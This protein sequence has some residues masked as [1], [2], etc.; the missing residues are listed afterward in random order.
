MTNSIV[1]NRAGTEIRYNVAVTFMDDDIREA[2]HEQLSPCT[3]QEFFTA[4]EQAHEQKHG[5]PW[6]LSEEHPQY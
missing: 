5:E 4:Y 6:F 3:D 1:I 2:L